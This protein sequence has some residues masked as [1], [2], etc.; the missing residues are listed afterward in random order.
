MSRITQDE[1]PIVKKA[2]AEGITVDEY[3][4]RQEERDHGHKKQ[5]LQDKLDEESLKEKVSGK[6]LLGEYDK[7]IEEKAKLNRP[8]DKDFSDA[9]NTSPND[10]GATGQFIAQDLSFDG[11][12]QFG[13]LGN[14]GTAANVKRVVMYDDVIREGQMPGMGTP[15]NEWRTMEI[16]GHIEVD[17]LSLQHMAV[18]DLVCLRDMCANVLDEKIKSYGRV[19]F[20]S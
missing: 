1:S 9:R 10:I 2:E 12:E 4:E 13:I 7:K 14:Y 3:I 6:T 8:E 18:E 16:I 19:T 17:K 15:I 20:N 11:K 5:R